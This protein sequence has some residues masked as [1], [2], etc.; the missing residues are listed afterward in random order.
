MSHN[1]GAAQALKNADLNLL[2]TKA[3][4]PIEPTPKALQVFTWQTDNQVC[5]NMDA[6]LLTQEILSYSASFCS[7]CLRLMR[8]ATSV[9]KV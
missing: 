3:H 4:Q 1:R 2:R 7:F 8:S 6:G 5:M 9:L